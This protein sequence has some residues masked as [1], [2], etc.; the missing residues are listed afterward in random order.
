MRCV[1][2][3]IDSLQAQITKLAHQF[4]NGSSLNTLDMGP[5][6]KEIKQAIVDVSSS[7]KQKSNISD[8]CALVDSKADS[9]YM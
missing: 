3:Q 5:E 8:V 6:L 2:E 4:Q 1:A 7:L 9:T